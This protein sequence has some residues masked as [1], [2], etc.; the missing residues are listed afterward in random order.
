MERHAPS[1]TVQT[2][3]FILQPFGYC[4]WIVESELQ[5]NPH[6][7]ILMHIEEFSTTFQKTISDGGSGS[8]NNSR[9]RLLGEADAGFIE[10][11][12]GF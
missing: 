12:H 8:D 11:L 3:N 4:F 9:M 1:R 2:N 10:L 6:S 5:R 7:P